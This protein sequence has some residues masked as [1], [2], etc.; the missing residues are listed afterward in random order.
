M[1]GER[2][3][4]R[5]VQPMQRVG[6]HERAAANAASGGREPAEVPDVVAGVPAQ[7]AVA[8]AQG[9]Q[10]TGIGRAADWIGGTTPRRGDVSLA[11]CGALT[12]PLLSS[13]G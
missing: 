12:R 1:R 4:P 3:P 2:S 8:C 9:D 6:P 10:R 5:V 11:N 13:T 7:D